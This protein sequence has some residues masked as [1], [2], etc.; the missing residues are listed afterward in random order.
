MKRITLLLTVMATALLV[1]SGVAWAVNKPC[2]PHQQVC[3]GTSGADVLKSTSQDNNMY[4][5][6]GNDSHSN[7][8][9]RNSHAELMIAADEQPPSASV[10][11]LIVG[12][13]QVPNG[14]YPFMVAIL[15]KRK[16][17]GALQEF[18]CAGT[19]IDKDS[20]LTAAHCFFTS[21]GYFAGGL[22]LVVVVGRTDLTQNQGQI[23]LISAIFIH[24]DYD[25]P[26]PNSSPNNKKVSW[27]GYDVAVL[28][29]ERA[30]TGIK[31][32]KLATAKQ[33]DLENPGTLL[34]V[35]GWGIMNPGGQP[36]ILPHRMREGSL[37][38]VSDSQAK[39]A[40]SSLSPYEFLP[41]FPSLMV[42]AAKKGKDTCRG[43]SGGPLFDSES[44]TQVGIT[45]T[46][47]IG[48]GGCGAAGY[49]GVYTEV[50]NPEIRNWIF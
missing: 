23:H 28:N 39:R 26:K 37:S 36:P 8:V 7:W 17:G 21:K 24:P 4:G 16:P 1:A 15:D 46:G 44:R 22:R 11:P 29:L 27:G 3:S 30:V 13:T 20:V 5:K 18:R 32:I 43:D 10:S 6:G 38:V 14:K 34:T 42:A 41:Y 40:Y 25:P 47:K 9:R 48:R 35:T 33:N 19:L 2:P 12:G 49:P 50:N 45:S 31:P